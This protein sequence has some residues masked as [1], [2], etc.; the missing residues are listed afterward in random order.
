VNVD[1]KKTISEAMLY[2]KLQVEKARVKYEEASARIKEEREADTRQNK[3][4]RTRE[5]YDIAFFE[6]KQQ[7]KESEIEAGDH[8]RREVLLGQMKTL[9]EIRDAFRP[10]SG[11]TTFGSWFAEKFFPWVRNA[12]VAQLKELV[13]QIESRGLG[14]FEGSGIEAM[15]AWIDV[16]LTKRQLLTKE[17]KKIDDDRRTRIE[18]Y[19]RERCAF[20]APIEKARE[21]RARVWA[22]REE[23]RGS[24]WRLAEAMLMPAINA[25]ATLQKA[26]D[27]FAAMY[28]DMFGSGSET[29]DKFDNILGNSRNNRCRVA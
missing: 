22:S 9:D 26:Y 12:K 17:L 5:G 24:D 4:E 18:G 21:E 11:Q 15:R 20:A 19:A 13:L 7:L 2:L 8:E 28:R 3:E 29:P 1:S 25:P 27:A 6:R 14:T 10:L 16:L 23:E